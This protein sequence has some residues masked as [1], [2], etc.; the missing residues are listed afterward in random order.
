VKDIQFYVL[1]SET[2]ISSKECTFKLFTK[3]YFKLTLVSLT[4]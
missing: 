4:K 3:Y 1:F 2:C